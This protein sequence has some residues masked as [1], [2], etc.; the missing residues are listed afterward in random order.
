MAGSVIGRITQNQEVID[1]RTECQTISDISFFDIQDINTVRKSMLQS[2][3]QYR[4]LTDIASTM[5]LRKPCV[6]FLLMR[7][8]L[9]RRWFFMIVLLLTKL[10]SYG[11][12]LYCASSTSSSHSVD[13]PSAGTSTAIWENQPSFAAPCQCF[14]P[15]GIFSA[16][17]EFSKRAG[18]SHY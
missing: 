4:F 1:F 15:G 5:E 14:V 11:R 6:I 12:T 13:T 7:N 2:E 16:S 17:P 10:I 3:V 9:L 8:H 18:L